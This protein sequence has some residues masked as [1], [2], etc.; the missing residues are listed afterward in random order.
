M[1]EI[2]MNNNC[3]FARSPLAVLTLFVT[4]AYGIVICFVSD[5]SKFQGLLER[6]PLIWF[7]IL[8]P[9]VVLGVLCWLICTRPE[10]MFGPSDFRT[11]NAFSAYALGIQVEQ[12]KG[13]KILEL[14]REEDDVEKGTPPMVQESLAI[15]LKCY[16]NAENW[17]IKELSAEYGI[18]FNPYF[19][20]NFDRRTFVF[21]AV[22]YSLGKSYCVEVKYLKNNKLNNHVL[23]GLRQLIIGMQSV[24]PQMNFSILVVLVVA[25][26]CDVNQAAL[27]SQLKSFDSSIEVKVYDY[28]ELE[29]RYA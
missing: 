25:S 6:L 14:L 23:N 8:F 7:M 4:I 12:Q 27:I 5:F 10:K 1:N 13:E 2:I 15:S 22:G 19:I 28:Q 9:L 17:S 29:K 26:I 24:G 20:V 16:E 11:D 3:K 21:D 18:D